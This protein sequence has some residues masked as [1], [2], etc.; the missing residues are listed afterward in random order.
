M[1]KK[2][3]LRNLSEGELSNN[4]KEMRIELMK[5]NA[6]VAAGTIPKNPGQIRQMK[7]T[8]ARIYTILKEKE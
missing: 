2:K 4:L 6:Q 5:A 3:D 8:I 7:K 1:V